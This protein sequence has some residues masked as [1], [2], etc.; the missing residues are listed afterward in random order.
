MNKHFYLG[1]RGKILLG[2]FSLVIIFAISAAYNIFSINRSK[3]VL[4]DL[5]ETK[6]PYLETLKDFEFLVSKSKMYTTNWVYLQKNVNDKSKLKRLLQ[7]DYL[8]IKS[9][10]QSLSSNL[11]DEQQEKNIHKIILEFEGLRKKEKC[12]FIMTNSY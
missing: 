1:I 11:N 3:K 12:L 2:F 9:Q 6:D 7:K 8:R 10:I 4:K 5:Y